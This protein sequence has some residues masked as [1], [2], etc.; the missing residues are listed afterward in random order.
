[1]GFVI[2]LEYTDRMSSN[3]K[4][5]TEIASSQRPPALSRA[6][7]QCSLEELV[8]TS[9]IDEIYGALTRGA[10][11]AGLSTDADQVIAWQSTLPSLQLQM[12]KLINLRPDLRSAGLFI[13]YE[14]P[15]RSKRIDAVLVNAECAHVI[16]FKTSVQQLDRASLWQVEDYALDLR[17]FH[18]G[19][20]DKQIS[21]SLVSTSETPTVQRTACSVPVHA[22][23][24]DR[25][26]THLANEIP[27]SIQEI[28]IESWALSQYDP[29]PDVI[30]ATKHLFA[31]HGVEDINRAGADNLD[32]TLKS[33]Q[34]IA[35]ETLTNNQHSICFVTGVPGS[36]KTL[37]GLSAAQSADRSIQAAYL[38]G[39]SPLIAVLREAVARDAAGRHGGIGQAR[40]YA[41]TL[42]Q[43]VHKFIE[44]YGISNRS[45]TPPESIV[46][47]D[48]A[49][50]AWH[51]EKMS[52]KR[53]NTRDTHLPSEPSLM[54]DIMGRHKN[55][56]LLIALVGNGQEIHDGEAG[57][58]EWIHAI[59]NSPQKWE[60]YAPP[61]PSN[62]EDR[63]LDDTSKQLKFNVNP[64]LHLTTV[65]RSPRATSISNWVDSVLKN[66]V[67]QAREY[68][69]ST[70]G[71]RLGLT[72]NLDSAKSWLRDASRNEMRAGLIAS[73]GAL[74]LRSEG[75]ELDTNF[76]RAFP[77]EKWF[78]N[79][80]EDI[81]SSH[82]LEVAMTEFSCQGLE[83]DFTGVCWGS[84]FTRVNQAWSH[85]K[86]VGSK[87]N[88]VNK[89]QN[90]LY[91]MN[92]YRVLLTR[93]REG[94][95]IFV[96]RGSKED[97]T[98]APNRLDSTAEYL[99]AC[100]VNMID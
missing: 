39:N 57:I 8:N 40:R 72:R 99:Q 88:R 43:N 85:R 96:P 89:P 6:W 24:I 48:E 69:D 46:V 11:R 42:I 36:G 67:D 45:H 30:S 64:G 15:R 77:I 94:M 70:T 5:T 52:K 55:G 10:A 4:Y 23:S 1:M 22:Y 74:R 18:A 12:G 54:L 19:S 83:I 100:G 31:N 82:C 51:A 58:T 90:Q 92:K 9:K 65:V 33:I 44:E 53:A 68:L 97:P 32:E 37:A 86:F 73:S 14:I 28:D 59:A 21:A 34:H 25:L 61:N 17:D 76:Q 91:L 13:E 2:R 16:E 7:Y 47:F 87:W 26:T 29:T 79:G 41:E 62:S 60:V 56:C 50:R 35:T 75:I 78:L 71:F 3:A 84:D 93:A 63:W 80:P 27:K 66:D 38:S 98:R 81:R 95:I 49:Q 20:R